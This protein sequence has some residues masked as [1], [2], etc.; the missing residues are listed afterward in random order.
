[1]K[2][3]VAQFLWLPV[4][5]ASFSKLSTMIEPFLGTWKLES[6]EN[7]EEYLEQLGVPV[8]IRHLA[9]L[10]KPKLSISARGGKVSIRTETSFKNFEISFRLGEEFDETTADNRK[11]K[12]IITLVNGSLVHVQKWLDKETAITRQIVHGKMIAKHTMNKVVSTRVFK[13]V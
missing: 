10:E 8:T 6:S 12:S 9:A 5:S 7:F 2:M 4:V 3:L 13:K 11:V 1:M